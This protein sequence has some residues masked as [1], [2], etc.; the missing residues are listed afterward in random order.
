MKNRLEIL[1][2]PEQLIIRLSQETPYKNAVIFTDNEVLSSRSLELTTEGLVVKNTVKQE[3]H[4]VSTL[5]KEV[6]VDYDK[7]N[8]AYLN[9]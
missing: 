7:I 2:S 9:G 6:L 5:L 8:R 4:A 1:G 3:K